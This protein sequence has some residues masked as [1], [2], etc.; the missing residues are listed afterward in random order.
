MERFVYLVRAGADHY[1]VGIAQDVFDRIKGIQTGNPNTVELISAVYVP[2]AMTIENKLHKWLAQ[3]KSDGGREWFQLNP[4]QALDLVVRMTSL[5]LTP[6]VSRYMTM[7]NL[8]VRQTKLEER[9]E[10]FMS[11]ISMQQTKE[12]V[13]VQPRETYEHDPLLDEALVVVRGR[14][15]AS[16]SFIQRHFRIGY[17]RAARIIDELEKLGVIGEADGARPRKILQEK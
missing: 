10:K 16:T 5:S 12:P 14:G 8:I 7:H 13:V 2:E 3:Y 1:K 6:D 15:Q 11:R 17:S 4:S 9:V